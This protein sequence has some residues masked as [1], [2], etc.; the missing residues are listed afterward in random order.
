MMFDE[1]AVGG[2]AST[3]DGDHADIRGLSTAVL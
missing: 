2:A 1:S 3:I